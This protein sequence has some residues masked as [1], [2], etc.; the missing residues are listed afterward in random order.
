MVD[1]LNPGVLSVAV[2]SNAIYTAGQN[3]DFTVTF[4]QAVDVV[5]TGGTPYLSVTFN[6]GGTVN[7]TYV[8][9][10]GTSALLFRYTVMSGQ[11]DADG[12]SVGSGITLNG[13][14]IKTAPYWMPSLP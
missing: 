7:A 13:G 2:P 3:L 5:T 9:G 12:I 6:T 14:T 1:A 4:S 11:N 10:T 8:S